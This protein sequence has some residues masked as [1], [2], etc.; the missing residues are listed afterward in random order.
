MKIRTV[1]LT[2]G[3]IG[4]LGLLAGCE[5]KGGVE[6]GRCIAYDKEGKTLTIVVESLA[7]PAYNAQSASQTYKLPVEDRDMG[8]EPRVGGLLAL[9][10]KNKT[11]LVF[12]KN[13][14]AIRTIS[15]PEAPTV[16]E[17]VDPAT[18][19]GKTF[20]DTSTAGMV[21][22]YSPSRKTLTTFKVP[23]DAADLDAYAWTYGDEMRV[24]FLNASKDQ[25]LRIMNTTKTS[26]YKRK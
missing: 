22:V 10:V 18:V 14:K 19:K 21:T 15:M 23:D 9:D 8:P 1:A 11:A 20:P 6:Q 26:I 12:D 17:K 5:L 3:M 24:A 4:A 16:K 2:L 13:A 25:A 7:S